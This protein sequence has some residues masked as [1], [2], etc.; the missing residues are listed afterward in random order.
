MNRFIISGHILIKPT[1][2][3]PVFLAPFS[4]FLSLLTRV[5]TLFNDL[6]PLPLGKFIVIVNLLAL[7]LALAEL[8]DH[9]IWVFWLYLY[10]LGDLPLLQQSIVDV[11]WVHRLI[12]YTSLLVVQYSPLYDVLHPCV[13]T[14][15]YVAVLV[16]FSEEF[17]LLGTAG[18]HLI[19]LVVSRYLALV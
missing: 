5:T 11:R 18:D 7:T 16:D 1:I 14:I 15:L 17:V 2:C 8:L 4:Q 12:K 6:E 19:E 3:T 9:S 13:S 10:P